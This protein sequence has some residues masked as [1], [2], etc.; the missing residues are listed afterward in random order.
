MSV[1]DVAAWW[2]ALVGT[3]VL[4]WR[5]R[6]WR[7]DKNTIEVQATIWDGEDRPEGI[8]HVHVRVENVG[9]APEN[10]SWIAGYYRNAFGKFIKSNKE[11]NF[12]PETLLQQKTPNILEPAEEWQFH[13]SGADILNKSGGAKYFYVG[14]KRSKKKGS[15]YCRIHLG[16]LKARMK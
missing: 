11:Y 16:E 2:G 4:L 10:L 6:E 12:S 3:A 1:N 8:T 15:I 9:N 14:V 5:I 7:Y 13:I